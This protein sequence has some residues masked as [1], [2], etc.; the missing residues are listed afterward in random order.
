MVSEPFA[1]RGGPARSLPSL[2]SPLTYQAD[3]YATDFAL[4]LPPI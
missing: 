3:R 1:A 2:P 4:D